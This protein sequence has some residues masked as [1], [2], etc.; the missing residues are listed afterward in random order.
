MGRGDGRLG[1]K[2]KGT[3][4][5]ENQEGNPKTI[6]DQIF[7]VVHEA[8]R[9]LGL[10]SIKK[11]LV[12]KYNRVE[13]KVFGS[14]VRKAL[15]ELMEEMRKDFG[16]SGGSYHG[17]A[18]SRSDPARIEE[19]ESEERKVAAEQRK[20]AARERAE[21][22]KWGKWGGRGLCDV[23]AI[24]AEFS[25]GRAEYYTGDGFASDRWEYVTKM[26]TS[27]S[28]KKKEL[29]R[30]VS[31]VKFWKQFDGIGEDTALTIAI[32]MDNRGLSTAHYKPID[33]RPAFG[34]YSDSVIGEEGIPY[35][36]GTK[37]GPQI[38]IERPQPVIVATPP[39]SPAKKR[40]R[41]DD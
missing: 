4:T 20:I 27:R 34:E 6:K 11:E 1:K 22:E 8:D 29:K 40:R 17:G 3:T 10:A 2:K 25:R 28:L 5:V 39:P 16:K 37:T 31:D 18:G 21:W 23:V 7:T 32:Y 35:R 15:K 38:V 41:Y 12:L 26:L 13:S 33:C 9:P 36:D 14:H 19:R 30:N 24:A